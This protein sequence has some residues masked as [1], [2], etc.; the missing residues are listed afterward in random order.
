LQ[1]KLH[2]Q[3]N[4][5]YA[6]YLFFGLFKDAVRSSGYIVSNDRMIN[7]WWIGHNIVTCIS[8]YRRGLDWW[9]DLLS[10]YKSWL[11]I[12]TTLLQSRSQWTR[13]LKHERSSPTRTLGSWVRIPL[14]AWMSVCVY[15]LFVLFC[16]QVAVLRR[17]DPLSKESSRLCKRSRNWK[18]AKV[19]QKTVE[20]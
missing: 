5:L 17:A 20:P 4:Q 8:D 13:G 10:T 19:Q 11:Q 3:K 7:E 18:A 15:S 2:I 1:C 14:E 6:I 16:V 12:T 9:I